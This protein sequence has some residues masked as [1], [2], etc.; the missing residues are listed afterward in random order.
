MKK[1]IGLTIVSVAFAAAIHGQTP[2]PSGGKAGG[3]PSA[4]K[5]GQIT[6]ESRGLFDTADAHGAF[7][8]AANALHSPTREPLIRAFLLF[9]EGD[10]YD[11]TKVAESEK[12]L[13]ALDFIKSV[14]ITTGPPHDGVVDVRVE[15][16]D[17]WTSDP[18]LDFGRSGGVGTWNLNLTQKD[19]LGSGAEVSISA[20]RQP[21]RS[22]NSFELIHPAF[23]HAYWDADLLLAKRSDGSEVK[24]GLTQPFYSTS[25]PFSF[26]LL[27]DN[28]SRNE[29]TY[30]GGVAISSFHAHN[31]EGRAVFGLS[32][33]GGGAG[34]Q[35]LFTGFDWLS[36][37][38]GLIG[39]AAAPKSRRYGWAIFGYEYAH[40]DLTKLNYVDR[41]EKYEDFDV[42]RRASVQLG[43]SPRS[44]GSDRMMEELTV[45]F[46]SGLR[47]GDRALLVPH[48]SF[49][50]RFGPRTE[51]QIRSAD[52][53]FIW[54]A[55]SRVLQ[56]LVSRVHVDDGHHLDQDVQFF[57]DGLRGLR[58]YPA[59][60]F[61]GDR[62]AVVNVE[63]RF[64]LGREL[65]HLFAPGA[66]IFMDAGRAGPSSG[67]FRFTGL[68]RDVGVGLRIA[69]P[70]AESTLLRFDAARTLD[71]APLTHRG[72]TFSFGTSQAF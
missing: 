57:A 17:E 32:L 37:D 38:F 48:V 60:A 68:K 42:G 9:R 28:D 24:I 2:G 54:R 43:L 11:A 6:V 12:N 66:A 22:E 18:N 39:G 58:A 67:P 64:F 33:P 45:Q 14:T 51:N 56:T 15:T 21:E 10:A 70:R 35:R 46:S 30:S 7:Y 65:L 31:R 44:A 25:T 40:E 23:L 50:S 20:A 1:L 34:A 5:I 71:P 62:S 8:R 41:D 49:S 29:R 4:L 27:Y 16:E 52:V 13:R 53:K 69:I 36:T 26:D 72:F 61:A 47:L 19:L 63:D 3:V 55:D 59:F